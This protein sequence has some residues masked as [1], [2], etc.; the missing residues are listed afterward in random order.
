M[1]NKKKGKKKKK[2]DL[3]KI[4]SSYKTIIYISFLI[5]I[6]LIVFTYY[7]VSNN[8]IY[9]FSGSDEYIEVNDGLIVLNT[10]INLLNGNNISYK[11]NEDYDIVSFKIGYYVMDNEKLV[12]IMSNNIKLESD[13]K[14]SVLFNNISSFNVFE[15][16]S[17]KNYFTPYKKK[18]LD[19]GLYLVFEAKTKDGNSIMRKV[20]M[21][22][23][24]ISKF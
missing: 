1:K 7:T 16:N 11:Y 20:K 5:N 9:S 4:L 17:S 19:D 18:L 12:E 8:K 21:N 24:K 13:I 2:F 10:D 23:S 15:K 22:L 6:I 3:K 14:L